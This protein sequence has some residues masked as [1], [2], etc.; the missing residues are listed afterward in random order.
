M[1]LNQQIIHTIGCN[2]R[3]RFPSLHYAAGRP[4]TCSWRASRRPRA[5]WWPSR[6]AAPAWRAAALAVPVVAAACLLRRRCSCGSMAVHIHLLHEQ[7]PGRCLAPFYRWHTAWAHQRLINGVL[8]AAAGS[9]P[10]CA[11][12][13]GPGPVQHPPGSSLPLQGALKMGNGNGNGR[14]K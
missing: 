5:G 14:S 4:W 3:E 12:H 1:Q 10:G 11:A 6:C 9:V 2:S 8:N 13:H 7:W